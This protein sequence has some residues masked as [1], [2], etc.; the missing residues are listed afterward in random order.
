MF[1][2]TTPYTNEQLG[3]LALAQKL[4]RYFLQLSAAD[5]L[6]SKVRSQVMLRL[7]KLSEL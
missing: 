2:S 7:T 1:Y 3:D 5:P 6:K 4:Y